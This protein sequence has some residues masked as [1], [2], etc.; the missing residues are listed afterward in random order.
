MAALDWKKLSTLDRVVAVTAIVTLIALFLPW[1]GYSEAGFSAS[2]SGFSTGYGWIGALLV[3]AAGVYLVR[4]RSGQ[5]LPKLPAGPAFV[6]LGASALGTI[7]IILRWVS[8]PKGSVGVA[9]TTF[10][11][12]GPRFGM[13]VALLAGVVQV[14]GATQLFRASGESVPWEKKTA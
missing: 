12:Y 4:L 2:V 9:G 7:L 5:S 14:V 8:L 1:Y 13:M 6:V 3:I 11:S 10:F